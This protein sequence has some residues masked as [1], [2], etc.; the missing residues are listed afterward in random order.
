MS[1]GGFAFVLPSNAIAKGSGGDNLQRKFEG[2]ISHIR[3]CDHIA[4]TLLVPHLEEIQDDARRFLEDERVVSFAES[5]RCNLTMFSP[6]VM[7]RSHNV[8]AEK[9]KRFVDFRWLREAGAI[10]C[11]FL[12]TLGVR[13][14]DVEGVRARHLDRVSV[15]EQEG[16]GVF[17]PH[18]ND[19]YYI[20]TSRFK[21]YTFYN[22]Q[23]TLLGRRG[24]RT[25]VRT[26]ASIRTPLRR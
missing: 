24:S 14:M 12:E 13:S 4:I 3:Y 25:Y 21:P 16:R 8:S 18:S 19:R 7:L 10:R 22:G 15:G 1:F 11:H 17:G 9:R 2:D 5:W 26:C 6:L 23:Q 20:K